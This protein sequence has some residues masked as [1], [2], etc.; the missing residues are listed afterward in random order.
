MK[1]P[2][3]NPEEQ[4]NEVPPQQET[5]DEVLPQQKVHPE[6]PPRS[7]SRKQQEE[8]EHHKEYKASELYDTLL[9]S[10]KDLQGRIRAFEKRYP[11]PTDPEVAEKI[12]ELDKERHDLHLRLVEA[13]KF[14]DKDEKDVLIDIVRRNRTLEEY[15]LPEFSILTPDDISKT[16]EWHDPYV[17]G[18]DEKAG[19]PEEITFKY[20]RKPNKNSIDEAYR[21]IPE[22]KFV[23]LF[24]VDY[25]TTDENG[26][27]IENGPEDHTERSSRAYRLAKEAGGEILRLHDS[28]YHT[29]SVS[30]FGVTFDKKDFEKVVQLI[31]DNPQKFRLGKEFYD[32]DGF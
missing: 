20:Y 16:G 27:D 28:D 31:R 32:K 25:I 26:E 8:E 6:R 10:Y 22:N 2:E 4:I 3:K 29:A 23:L 9:R 21:V 19:L 30:I 5:R 14:F 12:S 18:V 15:G 1:N 13:G 11:V 24:E 17:F 7:M